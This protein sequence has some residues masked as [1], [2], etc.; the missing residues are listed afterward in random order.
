VVPV[1]IGLAGQLETVRHGIDG[2]H[3]QTLGGLTAMTRQLID[4]EGSRERMASSALARARAFDIDA[5]EVHVRA[6]VDRLLA[7]P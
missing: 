5:F 4:D 7:E 2:L 6:V 3:F 1:V